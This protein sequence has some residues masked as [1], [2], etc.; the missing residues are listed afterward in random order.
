[1]N[2]HSASAAEKEIIILRCLKLGGP[3]F[4]FDPVHELLVRAGQVNLAAGETELGILF[5]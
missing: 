1:M 2:A 5:I 3:E 4:P